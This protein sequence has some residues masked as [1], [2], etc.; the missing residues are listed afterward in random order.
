MYRYMCTFTSNVCVHR[1]AIRRAMVLFGIR[2]GQCQDMIKNRKGSTNSNSFEKSNLACS[3]NHK[4]ILSLMY[5][6]YTGVKHSR[7]RVYVVVQDVVQD[8]QHLAERD[9]IML[10]R[11]QRRRHMRGNPDLGL[12]NTSATMIIVNT[13]S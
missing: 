5:I 6:D 10:T 8:L 9:F 7:S 1:R 3:S 13:P 4:H 2:L 12:G 11:K